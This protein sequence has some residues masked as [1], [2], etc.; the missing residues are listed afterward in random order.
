MLSS[1]TERVYFCRRGEDW[2]GV[3]RDTNRIDCTHLFEDKEC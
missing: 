1:D 3:R 2:Y